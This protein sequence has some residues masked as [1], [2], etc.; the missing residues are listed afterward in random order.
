MTAATDKLANLAAMLKDAQDE[1]DAWQSEVERVQG[2]LLDAVGDR[3]PQTVQDGADSVRITAV[4]AERVVTD[5]TKLRQKLGPILWKL[6]TSQVLDT[7]KLEAAITTGQINPAIVAAASTI[8]P[9]KPYV[10][11]T[12]T[13]SKGGRRK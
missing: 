3:G 9:N 11:V 13:K 5:P 2:M 6:V 10:K 4:R 8:V 12:R 1:R 7:R